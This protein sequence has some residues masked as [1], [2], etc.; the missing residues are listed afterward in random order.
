M[1]LEFTVIIYCYKCRHWTKGTNHVN[2]EIPSVYIYCT[3]CNEKI[4]KVEIKIE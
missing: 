1:R 3:E 2:D 4:A